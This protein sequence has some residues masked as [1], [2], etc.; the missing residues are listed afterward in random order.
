MWRD[1]LRPEAACACAF[2]FLYLAALLTLLPPLTVLL[3]HLMPIPLLVL[4][5]YR[6]RDLREQGL[7]TYMPD[8]VQD[9]LLHRSLLDLL[10]TVWDLPN[11]VEYLKR[12]IYPFFVRMDKAEALML[13]E[14]LNPEVAAMMNTKGLVHMLPAPVMKAIAPEAMLKDYMFMQPAVHQRP[15]HRSHASADLSKDPLPAPI[16]PRPS[17]VSKPELKTEVISSSSDIVSPALKGS[18][19]ITTVI[20]RIRHKVFFT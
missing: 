11:L 6:C 18:D 3:M 10:M 1:W 5:Y 15:R 9:V 4:C 8:K 20:D 12:L 7:V 14:E 17:L 16:R 2:L 13:F 19:N